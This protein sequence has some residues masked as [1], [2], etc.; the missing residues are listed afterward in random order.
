MSQ[1]FQVAIAT[2]DDSGSTPWANFDGNWTT[3][4]LQVGNSS[5]KQN[6]RF[7]PSTSSTTTWLPA[8]GHW[9]STF[10]AINGGPIS[11]E[12]YYARRGVGFY[13]G[14]QNLG[15]SGGN[16]SSYEPKN[17]GDILG[18]SGGLKPGDIFGP[19]Y[20]A[21][22]ELGIDTLFLNNG[23]GNQINSLIKV[24]ILGYSSFFYYSPIVGLGFEN[25]NDDPVNYVTFM[26]S[27]ADSQIIP[28]HSFGYTAGAYRGTYT[29]IEN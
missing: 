27:L 6:F 10:S 26:Q 12:D 22:G 4:K 9:N 15:F 23:S 1:P 17:T 11:A 5:D 8:S 2:G 28:S 3:F 19:D 14:V 18:L 29:L 16:S 20:D 25:Y 21:V 24:P 7:V 13:D